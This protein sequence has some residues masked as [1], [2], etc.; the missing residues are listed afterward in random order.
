M[1]VG[2]LGCGTVGSEVARLLLDGA[3]PGMALGRVAVHDP[4][5]ER[6][7]ELPDGLLTS[8][9]SIVV[10]DPDIDLVIELIG[11]LEP[12]FALIR[13]ALAQNKDVITAN[14]VVI[15]R[16]GPL[17]RGIA[18]KRSLSLLYEGAA[19]AS[20]PIVRT[21]RSVAGGDRVRSIE[22]VLNGTTNFVLSEME[23]GGSFEGA[24][25]KAQLVGYAEADP[26]DDIRGV[27]AAC[28]LSL[29]IS[30]AFGIDV[31]PDSVVRRGIE[32][33]TGEHVRSIASTGRRLKLVAKAAIA[34]DGS[35]LASVGPVALDGGHP[36]ARVE[37]AENGVVL[38]SECSGRLSLFGEGAGGLPTAAA[39]LTDIE[40][41]LKSHRPGGRLRAVPG[42]IERKVS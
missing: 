6:A 12:S 4:H 14:K 10:T 21:L 34:S 41:V 40:E 38:E 1:R 17:L 27:D 15:A 33:V 16:H 8:D 22:G 23:K 26:A 31:S 5:K 13:Q 2:L 25:R 11:G 7:V 32:D 36:L 24:V 29:L 19:C 3:V 30:L 9:A 39:I 18:E 20:V 35:V 37:G 42:S 28:K